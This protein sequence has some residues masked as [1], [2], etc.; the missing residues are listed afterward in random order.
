MNCD[1]GSVQFLSDT[2]E[3]MVPSKGKKKIAFLIPSVAARS[4]VFLLC[5]VVYLYSHRSLKQHTKMVFTVNVST[6]LFQRKDN[7]AIEF[8]ARPTMSELTTVCE[9]L[10]DVAMRGNRPASS[11]D[12]LF[13]I[14][15]FQYFDE[16]SGS[17][18]ELY[19]QLQLTDGC[20][21]FAFQPANEGTCDV[22]AVVPLARKI[23][24]WIPTPGSAIPRC[25]VPGLEIPFSHRR[26]F[27]FHDIARQQ[28]GA[29]T[30]WALRNS[31]LLS[32]IDVLSGSSLNEV[33]THFDCD[34]DGVLNHGEFTKLC[35]MYPDLCDALYY[36]SQDMTRTFPTVTAALDADLQH[37]RIVMQELLKREKIAKKIKQSKAVERLSA[38]KSAEV[39]NAEVRNQEK[40]IA[41]LAEL[42]RTKKERVIRRKEQLMQ[43][44][45]QNW[46]ANSGVGGLSMSPS[47][48]VNNLGISDVQRSQIYPPTQ[49]PLPVGLASPVS[50]VQSPTTPSIKR[51]S[52]PPL[53]PR[54][55]STV[56]TSTKNTRTAVFA[57]R[58][59]ASFA[60]PGSSPKPTAPRSPVTP[61]RSNKKHSISAVSP[62]SPAPSNFNL[63]TPSSAATPLTVGGGVSSNA[64]V[65]YI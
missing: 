30:Y 63:P 21:V 51:M 61:S 37:E 15:Q 31:L 47:R 62:I 45:M 16:L 2:E 46:G 41:R 65:Y 33:F 60:S 42:D 4:V 40:W 23:I 26:D 29:I 59:G 11:P 9:L 38:G 22:Q 8:P 6:D 12:Y 55:S 49:Y 19:N 56:S 52:S 10:F 36:R 32:Q 54:K 25:A 1:C 3:G 35:D 28:Q 43:Q 50:V 39:T 24:P 64:P 7:I 44:E 5:V 13:K 20:Q 53:S 27:V 18:T 48:V 34:K 58:R 57:S 14:Q 17:W